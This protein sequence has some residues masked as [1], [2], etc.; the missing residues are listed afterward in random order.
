MRQGAAKLCRVLPRMAA[1]L[2]GLPSIRARGWPCGK[3][4]DVA[5]AYS[6]WQ[7]PLAMSTGTLNW[8]AYSDYQYPLFRLS[9]PLVPII[10]TPCYEHRH[11]ELVRLFRLSVP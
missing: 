1:A 10:S 7:S 8:C 2:D 5:S 6:E 3:G 4:A 11:T 9:V